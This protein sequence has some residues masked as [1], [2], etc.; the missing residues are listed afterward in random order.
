MKS[1]LFSTLV[2]A[3]VI[4]FSIAIASDKGNKTQ[5]TS[6]AKKETQGCCMTA[7]ETKTATDCSGKAMMDC[8]PGD[9]K[10]AKS[11]KKSTESKAEVKKDGEAK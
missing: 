1:K 7:K 10:A 9:A 4:A 11:S 3:I 2:V 5:K 6:E 8:D